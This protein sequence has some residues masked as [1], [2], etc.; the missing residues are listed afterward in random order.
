[1]RSG[2]LLVAGA[3]CA[4]AI[5]A[6]AQSRPVQP[7]DPLPGVTPAEFEEFR[8]GLDDFLEVE[9]ADEVSDPRST[10]RAVPRATTYRPSA[11]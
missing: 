1:M 9:T 7:G 4:A 8:L 3:V 11:G 5:V 6:R 10:A 2:W